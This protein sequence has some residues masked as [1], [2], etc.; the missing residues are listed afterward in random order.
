MKEE[1]KRT[2]EKRNKEEINK[3]KANA[4]LLQKQ[5]RKTNGYYQ[6][7]NNNVAYKVFYPSNAIKK[8]SYRIGK[9]KEKTEITLYNREI[10]KDKVRQLRE[11]EP[12]LIKEKIDYMPYLQYENGF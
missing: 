9:Q 1:R 2:E 11:I 6:I 4:D 7:T 5:I 3:L 12:I 8:M 10:Q